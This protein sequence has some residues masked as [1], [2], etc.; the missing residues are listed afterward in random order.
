MT[1]ASGMVVRRQITVHAPIE[2]AF[3]VFTERFG[4]RAHLAATKPATPKS[5]RPPEDQLAH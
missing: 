2:Q 4:E 1:Q 3:A 5:R